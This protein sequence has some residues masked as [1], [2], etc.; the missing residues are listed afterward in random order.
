MKKLFLL[1]LIFSLVKLLASNDE[2]H[3]PITKDLQQKLISTA[4]EEFIR[5]NI[6]MKDQFDASEFVSRRNNLTREQ[7][8]QQLITELKHITNENQ[9]KVVNELIYYSRSG[10]VKD[11]KALWIANI[12]N[13]HATP[14]VV[15]LLA[16]HPD[17]ERIDIDE[18]RILLFPIDTKEETRSGTREITYN[19][20]KVNAPGVWALGFT[21]EGIVVAVLDTGVN[22]DHNDLQGN[23]W[24]HPDYP[25]HGWNFISNN[26]N[27]MDYHGHGTHCAGTV[28]GNGASGSQTGMAPEA[29][30]M[31]L[32]VLDD[33][34]SG[35]E[36]GV[37]NAIQFA[38][39]NGA[40]VM[41]LSL[42]W[43]HIW[44]PD[45]ATWRNVMNN[46]LAAG[47]IAS[48]AA[49]NEGSG[50]APSNVRT[51]GDVPPPWLNPDQTLTGGI[52]AVVSVGATDINDDIAS[53][54]SRGP[55]TW[56]NIIPF[57]DYPYDPGMGLIR[58]DVSA[59]GV[60]VKS[61]SHSNT[62]GYTTMSGTSMATPG[63]AGVMALL[64]SK[65]PN[66]TPVVI[67]QALELTSLDLGAAGKDNVFGAGR[68]DALEAIN[69]VNYPG[70]VYYSHSIADPNSNG[71]I[72]AGESILLS[73]AM[74]N[75]S[76][77]PRT[78]VTVTLSSDS[79][80]ITITDNSEFYGSFS[81]WEYKTVTNGFV[82]NVASTTPGMEVIRFDV[83]ATDGVET[84]N[85]FF[86]I[87][88][89][90]PRLVFGN[91]S[92]SDPLGNNNG[93]MDPGEIVDLIIAASNIGQLPLNDVLVTISSLSSNISIH[94]SEFNIPSIPA[95]SSINALFNIS[96][97]AAAPVGSPVAFNF[98]MVSGFYSSQK[99]QTLVIGQIPALI[100]NLDPN[101]TSA[102]AMATAM[103]AL[104]VAYEM[105]TTFPASL[106]LYSSVFLCLGIFSNNTV[107]SAAQGAQ[108]AAYLNNGGQLYMEGGDTWAYDAQTQVHGMFKINGISD[109]TADMGTVTGKT[110][111]FT[112]G[113]SFSYVGE[114]N[115]MDRIGAISPAFLILENTSPA[116]GTGV[117]HDAGTY[118]TIGTSHEF[119]GLAEGTFPSTKMELMNQYLTFFGIT[120]TP[121]LPPSINL[122]PLSFNVTLE[123]D[124]TT[125]TLLNI[126]N[127]GEQN[128]TFNISKVIDQE[129]NTAGNKQMA[130]PKPEPL[131]SFEEYHEALITRIAAEQ[132]VKPE[133]Y[134]VGFSIPL[135][136][137]C[138]PTFAY[139][140][141]VG[142]G[143][144]DFAV[145]Q[146][147]NL[148]NGCENNTGI[149]GWSTY[150]GLG[151]AI[152]H[153][154]QEYTFAMRTGYSNQFV[155]IWIDFND[156]NNLTPDKR[157]LNNYNM[158]DANTWYYVP[159]TIPED[160]LPGLHRMRAMAR[161][162]SAFDDPCGSYSWGETEDYYVMIVSDFNDWLTIDSESGSVP[163]NGSTNV[164]LFFNA[165]GLEPGAY[166]AELTVSSNDPLSPSVIIP[167]TLNVSEDVIPEHIVING[168]LNESGCFNAT[169][170]VVID[171]ANVMSGVMVEVRSGN[172]ITASD[173]TLQ[174]GG[175]LRLSAATS[176]H[177]TQPASIIAGVEGLFIAEITASEPCSLA[178]SLLAS[179][180]VIATDEMPA[181]LIPE[182][183]FNVF[184]NPTTGRFLLKLNEPENYPEMMLEIFN[185]M[186]ERVRVL[187]LSGQQQYELDLTVEPHGMYLIR[188]LTATSTTTKRLIKQ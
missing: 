123:P 169:S 173:L 107:L 162:L 127:T 43:R 17:V 96:V 26:N 51:P 115:W 15:R 74:F 146:I 7:V 41:S 135:D 75:G 128:L 136:G 118:K 85:S 104:D 23:M 102:P 183:L 39:D 109:G 49:G 68:V 122:N 21:G 87:T 94:N 181:L 163:G 156:D 32:K 83:S 55:V 72:E 177:I 22:Y 42:G 70:P 134:A 27:P 14:E 66:L 35:T 84:W 159:V 82:F 11:I 47:V 99:D 71:E 147:Q 62:S 16:T 166:Y 65:N 112:E 33:S 152:L 6:R 139:G 24:T 106:D 80:Y 20:A 125:S 28:A 67:S 103:T 150:Y 111:T 170:T 88:T 46:A 56:Q 61:L 19:V 2:Q 180:E 5:I 105:T 73:I 18:E 9:K 174:E 172:T 59:P 89:Y 40:H 101:N 97:S 81:A 164:E 161:W 120:G 171:G 117:A 119:S 157:I 155:N 10:V 131:I 76:D 13:C 12:I 110:G 86:E 1:F 142:D 4:E 98:E 188:V 60:N 69:N 130:L 34:G 8:R 90:G 165:T 121:L 186:G 50:A 140:C 57:N 63:V 167:V 29:K 137:L 25:F 129:R 154:G 58:P 36:S 91:V 37:W 138:A 113:M 53:F 133:P 78:N 30:I 144:T 178:E 48:V 182:C 100:L 3:D 31:A 44:N 77:E 108:L 93:R 168:Q 114:N 141:S 132:P 95:S 184:P 126:G 124:G 153:A 149:T 176:I 45:R 143:F 151:P 116:Y 54:S 64:L 175:S 148:E 160:A 158:A 92:V 185:L 187:Q 52:S 38:V 79:P 179:E 145:E